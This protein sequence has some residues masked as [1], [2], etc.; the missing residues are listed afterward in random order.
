MMDD[1]A[2]MKDDFESFAENYRLAGTHLGRAHSK[3]VEGT[4]KLESLQRNLSGQ[5]RT[6]G[7]STELVGEPEH[8][9]DG[10]E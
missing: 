6:A 8:T 5:L 4:H 10:D 1:L 2:R 7:R 9:I 3:Y